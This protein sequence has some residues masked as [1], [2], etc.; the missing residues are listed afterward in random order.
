MC[1]SNV[2]YRCLKTSPKRHR[3]V[4]EQTT[5]PDFR[6][7]LSYCRGARSTSRG[8]AGAAGTAARHRAGGGGGG[9]EA[10]TP[11]WEARKPQ[12]Q[13]TTLQH[14]VWQHYGRV[15]R[16]FMKRSTRSSDQTSY[17]NSVSR[18]DRAWYAPPVAEIVRGFEALWWC[19]RTISI[20]EHKCIV[21]APT[22]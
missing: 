10:L 19:P 14:I 5:Y 15:L 16:N 12:Q 22:T 3:R 7:Q 9:I 1:A 17:M 13:Q 2:I 11:T 18:G 6:S 20:N 8:A 4:E 21:Q